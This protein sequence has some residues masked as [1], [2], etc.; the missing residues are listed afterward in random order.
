[1]CFTHNHIHYTVEPFFIFACPLLSTQH[2]ISTTLIVHLQLRLHL[3]LLF[4]EK[5]LDTQ[6]FTHPLLSLTSSTS[7]A[8]F[9][10]QQREFL[11]YL[12][13]IIP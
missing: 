11:R 9:K 1:M 10:Y 12:L 2:A 13:L 4:Y 7:K 8:V 6:N 5:K 3:N